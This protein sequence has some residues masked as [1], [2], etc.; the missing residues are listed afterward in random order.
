MPLS[1]TGKTGGKGDGLGCVSV[2]FRYED[3]NVLGSIVVE[4]VIN[5]LCG[6]WTLPPPPPP[7]LLGTES[8]W[9]V[10][11]E[12]M[13]L[14]GGGLCGPAKGRAP[15]LLHGRPWPPLLQWANA[16]GP[17][18]S[19]DWDSVGPLWPAVLHFQVVCFYLTLAFLLLLLLRG[20][21]SIIE[22]SR[23]ENW[24]LQLPSLTFSFEFCQFCLI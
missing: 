19:S 16:G 12:L 23:L 6:C 24:N 7:D 15:F 18:C 21:S 1:A 9:K 14:P 17:L 22:L 11:H 5:Q 10:W 3:P 2:C 4:K 8:H 20:F 13:C